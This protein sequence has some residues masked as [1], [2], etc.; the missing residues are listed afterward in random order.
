MKKRKLGSVTRF[1]DDEIVADGGS[2]ESECA[3]WWDSLDTIRQVAI[4]RDC[5]AD[6]SGEISQWDRLVPIGQQM[7]IHMWY[8]EFERPRPRH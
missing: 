2:E 8:D 6:R 1:G 4:A 5:G 7:K 3:C